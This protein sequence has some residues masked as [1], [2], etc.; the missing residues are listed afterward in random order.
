MAEDD[1]GE[2][3]EDPTERRR[4]EDEEDDSDDEYDVEVVRVR[5]DD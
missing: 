3:T 4:E 2:K 5:E 1:S